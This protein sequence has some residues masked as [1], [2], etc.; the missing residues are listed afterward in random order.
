MLDDDEACDGDDFGDEA[1]LP[2]GFVGGQ[3]AC[4]DACTLD[5]SACTPPDGMAFVPEGSFLMGSNDHPDELPVRNVI[6]DGYF[7]D[8]TEV[9]AGDYQ[10]CIDAGS[11]NVPVPT[12][13]PTYNNQCN[14]GLTGREDHPVN[15]IAMDDA[16]NYCGVEGKR[17]PTE[18][19]WEK[20]ARGTDGLRYPWGDAPAP[21]AAC[22]YAVAAFGPG[23]GCGQG[24][25]APVGSVPM[26]DSP[27]G[28]HDMAGNTWEWVSDFYAAT[29]DG[30]ALDNPTGPGGGTEGVLRGGGW[31][32]DDTAAFTT[33]RRY[34]AQQTFSDAFVGFRCVRPLERVP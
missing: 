3:L 25:S 27:Y 10:A 33:T 16:A 26:G 20:A 1:C 23:L 13:S 21:S 12:G 4:S 28:L 2:Y 7:I 8:L 22:E 9:T 24:S 32:S 17:L 29:Y 34:A 18:A 14:I 11:C 15:C 31:Y 5:F 19:E 30:A 6:L